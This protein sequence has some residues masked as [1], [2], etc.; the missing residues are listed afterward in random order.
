L[1]VSQAMRMLFEGAV[2]ALLLVAGFAALVD[3]GR[4]VDLGKD[5]HLAESNRRAA[6][7]APPQLVVGD[8]G[9]AYWVG[10]SD[11]CGA[12]RVAEGEEARSSARLPKC[13]MRTW[14]HISTTRQPGGGPHGAGAHLEGE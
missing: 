10:W 8:R 13:G 1:E 12:P 11:S 2:L 5:A 4:G 3:L 9:E 14:P 6:Q 7:D